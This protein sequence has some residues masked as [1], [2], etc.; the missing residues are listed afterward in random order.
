MASSSKMFSDIN[1]DSPRCVIGFEQAVTL[2]ALNVIISPLGSIGNISVCATILCTPSLRTTSSYCVVNLALA[3][4]TVTMLVQPMV[5]GIFLGKLRGICFVELE[6]AARLI[7]SLSC[8]VSIL[9]L[10][11][12]S[13]ERCL[14]ISRPLRYKRYVNPRRLKIYL[15]FVWLVSFVFPS[16]DAFAVE[17]RVYPL[18]TASVLLFM[19][20]II[21]VCYSIIFSTA[22][23]RSRLRSELQGHKSTSG[24]NDKRLAKTIALVIGMFTLFWAPFVIYV[25]VKPQHNFGSVYMWIMSLGFSNS[26]INPFIYFFRSGMFRQALRDIVAECFTRRNSIRPLS[27]RILAFSNASQVKKEQVPLQTLHV[28]EDNSV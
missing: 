27:N 23:K 10:T 9:T 16:V 11:L 8:A 19:Y 7:G 12:M 17:R 26:G 18:F 20:G 22:R 24:E 5:V 15:S 2:V 4:L 14:V 21:I 3:D 6:Y 25:V 13:T 1:V 28:L